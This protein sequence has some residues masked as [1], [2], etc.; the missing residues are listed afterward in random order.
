MGECTK[1]IE[2][3]GCRIYIDGKEYPLYPNV[4]INIDSEGIITVNTIGGSFTISKKYGCDCLYFE[5]TPVEIPC[6]GL[7]EL[8][9]S[10][11]DECE[12]ALACGGDPGGGGGG[13]SVLSTECFE[14][15]EGRYNRILVAQQSEGGSITY[16]YIYADD[17]GVISGPLCVDPTPCPPEFAAAKDY[18]CQR[19]CF[20]DLNNNTVYKVVCEDFP[21][22]NGQPASVYFTDASGNV[23]TPNEADLVPCSTCYQVV[24]CIVDSN[25]VNSVLLTNGDIIDFDTIN[26][27]NATTIQDFAD[28]MVQTYGGSYFISSNTDSPHFSN[29]KANSVE[30]QF[31]NMNIFIDEVT[32]YNFINTNTETSVVNYYGDC[33]P[34]LDLN[35]ISDKIGEGESCTSVGSVGTIQN[36]NI[37]KINP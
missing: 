10:W 34:G 24:F 26:G 21:D 30:V 20:K 31:T 27:A 1:R 25:A 14:C 32:T 33:Q 7:Y 3:I 28:Y 4:V 23:I 17:T 12:C 29:C 36:W 15:P 9:L 2:R 6:D 19:Y 11:R 8:L 13:L 35:R 16:E 22:D 18:E 5:G 37:I